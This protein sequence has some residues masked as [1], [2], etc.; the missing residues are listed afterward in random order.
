MVNSNV[1]MV[2]KGLTMIEMMGV[3][4]LLTVFA[5]MIGVA[6]FNSVNQGKVSAAQAQI[7]QMGQALELYNALGGSDFPPTQDDASQTTR[8][9][10]F[11]VLVSGGYVNDPKADGHLDPWGQPYLYCQPSRLG[12]GT[13]GAVWSI[14][15]NGGGGFDCSSGTPSG[16]TA[17][18][19][20]FYIIPIVN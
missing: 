5:A 8:P 9:Q 19:A 14:G 1:G 3:A 10:W 2:R 11:E 4:V 18:N 17:E 13:N 16:S 6:I 12:T 20:L 7:R 15:P